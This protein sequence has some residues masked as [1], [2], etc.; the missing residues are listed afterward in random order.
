MKPEV[1]A[2]LLTCLAKQEASAKVKRPPAWRRLAR[3]SF[4]EEHAHGPQYAV[5][6]W[7][8]HV[9]E[10]QRLRYLRAVEEAERDGLLVTWCRHGRRLSRVKLTTGGLRVA[11]ELRSSKRAEAKA[12]ARA[13][14]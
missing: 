13:A 7:F 4:D 5:T 10:F 12:E 1:E 3:G 2:V 9:P 8:G 6:S 14:K 11:R